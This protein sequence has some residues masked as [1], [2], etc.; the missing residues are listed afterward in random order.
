MVQIRSAQLGQTDTQTNKQKPNN[1]VQISTVREFWTLST[2]CER[3]SLTVS[4]I[5]VN[6]IETLFHTVCMWNAKLK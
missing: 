5:Y 1:S 2:W 4:Q 6:S 3:E